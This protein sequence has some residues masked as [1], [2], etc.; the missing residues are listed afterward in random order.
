MS[1]DGPGS[2]AVVRKFAAG[3]GLDRG[4]SAHSMHATF[5]TTALEN[6][7]QLERCAKSPPAI[8]IP[9]PPRATILKGGI[10]LR[11]RLTYPLH[12]CGRVA[13]NYQCWLL[14]TRFSGRY[15]LESD[16]GDNHPAGA[17]CEKG[18]RKR[19]NVNVCKA[20]G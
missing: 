3:L 13:L 8:A 19:P 7:A 2:T 11:Y 16:E 17:A 15:E 20:G 10:V 5:I 6:G 18:H 14:I 12:D 4:Y 1:P 9:A